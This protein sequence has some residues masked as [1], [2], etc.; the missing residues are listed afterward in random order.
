[1]LQQS[2]EVPMEK[3]FV[4]VFWRPAGGGIRSRRIYNGRYAL[5]EGRY[6]FSVLD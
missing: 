6:K 4:A 1:L 3:S 2:L 5:G